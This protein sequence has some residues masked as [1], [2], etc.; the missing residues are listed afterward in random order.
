MYNS[1]PPKNIANIPVINAKPPFIETITFS[2][3]TIEYAI[4]SP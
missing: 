2:P 1:K 4:M 3:Q